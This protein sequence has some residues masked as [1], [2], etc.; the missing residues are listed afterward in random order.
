MTRPDRRPGGGFAAGKS[1]RERSL[2]F[3]Y[4][5]DSENT[6]AYNNFEVVFGACL[7]DI[8]MV[9]VGIND[10]DRMA[11]LAVPKSPAAERA[12]RGLG[13]SLITISVGSFKEISGYCSPSYAT[14]IY[15]DPEAATFIAAQEAQ[16]M[17]AN[18]IAGEAIVILS[19]A[20]GSGKLSTDFDSI[21]TFLRNNGFGQDAAYQIA[22]DCFRSLRSIGPS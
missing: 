9:Q 2:A 12:A 19:D 8:K 4:S 21:K 22:L 16:G 11:Y 13:L 10:S 3:Q 17:I 5:P 20:I 7:L 15:Q 6:T 1:S 14:A 18:K